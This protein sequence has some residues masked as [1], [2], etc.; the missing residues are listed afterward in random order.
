MTEDQIFARIAK[1][2][3]PFVVLLY[4]VNYIDRVNVGFAALT[5]NK[6]LSLSPSVFGLGASIF[7]IGYLIFQVPANLILDRIGARRWMFTILCVWGLLSASHAFLQ[8]SKSYYTLRLFLGIAE[9]GFF[10][11]MLLYMTYWFPHSWRSRFV[12]IFM[13]AIPA[14]NIIGGPLS[15][16]ILQLDGAYGLHGWQWMFILEGLPATLLAFASLK[17]LPDRPATASWLSDEEKR[18]VIARLTSE[19]RGSDHRENVWAALFDL[20]VVGLGLVLLGNQIGLYGVQLWLPQIVQGMG[21]SNFTNGFVVALCFISAMIAMIYWARHSDRH[22][23]RVWHVSSSLLLGAFGLAVAAV[24]QSNA[25]VLIALA[26]ALVGMLAYNGPFFSMPSTFLAGT[27]AAGGVGMVN[28]IGSFGRFIGP[29]GVGV[30]KES[31]GG[32]SAAMAAMGLAMLISGLIVVFM[33]RKISPARAG[34][35]PAP[36]S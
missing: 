35:S 18:I 23:E 19:E 2:L 34:I 15:T 31:T 16:T 32:Y 5:M 10:P 30:L 36:S 27:A 22:G 1:R 28:T 9:A 25:I 7:F 26:V 12:G 20:R 11:G 24:V 4:I 6:D 21:Y 8:G 14:A 17:L 29:W 13:A 33:G 3:L